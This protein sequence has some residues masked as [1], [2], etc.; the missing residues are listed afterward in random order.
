MVVVIELQDRGLAA[1]ESKPSPRQK[2]TT[3]MMVGIASLVDERHSQGKGVVARNIVA[4]L[5]DQFN[6]LI[7]RT[8][9]GRMISKLGLSWAPMKAYKSTFASHRKKQIRDFII[10]IDLYACAHNMGDDSCVFVFT[11]ESYVNTNHGSKKTYMHKDEKKNLVKVKSG[12]GRRLVIL[13]AITVD[14]PLCE[15]E[16]ESTTPIDDLEWRG[17]TCHP[18]DRPDGKLTYKTLWVAQSHTG[19]YHDNMTSAMFM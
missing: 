7:H 19:D 16:N 10:K 11:D 13:H 12:K 17:D 6:L 2:V 3:E 14:G 15:F 18:K 5:Y 1:T 8:T 9:A 4:Y